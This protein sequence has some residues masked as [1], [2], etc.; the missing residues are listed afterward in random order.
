M[1]AQLRTI[2]C[3]EIPKAKPGPTQGCRADDDDVI[4][5][6]IYIYPLPFHI[7]E[8]HSVIIMI[9]IDLNIRRYVLKSCVLLTGPYI[10]RKRLLNMRKISHIN[11]GLNLTIFQI[12]KL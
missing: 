10:F 5:I 2:N 3:P 4:Y 8:I 6:Y 11:T 9:F 12:L 1:T 7:C